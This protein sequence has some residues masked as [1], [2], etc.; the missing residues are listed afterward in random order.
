M[1]FDE[2]AI[3]GSNKIDQPLRLKALCDEALEALGA[4]PATKDTKALADKIQATLK[5]Q[6]PA[7]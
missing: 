1:L 5:K 2:S 4:I 3:F 6:R 7:T